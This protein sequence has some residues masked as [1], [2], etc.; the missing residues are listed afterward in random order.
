MTGVIDI[1]GDH[2]VTAYIPGQATANTADS[3][4]LLYADA[5]I[6]ITG[7]RWIPAAAVTGNNTNYFSLAVQNKGASGAGTTAITSTKDYL[8]STDSV[9][10][11]AEDLTLTATTA[12]RNVSAGSVVALVRTITASGLAQPD[13]LV[14]VRFRYR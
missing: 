4:P 13:G 6:E 12:N 14:E 3:W 2:K 1:P 8:T 5:D 9:A 11:D 7:V 10:H